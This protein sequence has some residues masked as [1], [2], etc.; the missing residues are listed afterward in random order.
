M[1][2]MSLANSELDKIINITLL[3]GK[4]G[5]KMTVPRETEAGVVLDNYEYKLR[6]LMMEK[7]RRAELSIRLQI[8]SSSY[9]ERMYLVAHSAYQMGRHGQPVTDFYEL[10][11]KQV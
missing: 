1:D 10:I 3:E 2:I 4:T 5:F 11:K 7:L 9:D 8:A 6:D